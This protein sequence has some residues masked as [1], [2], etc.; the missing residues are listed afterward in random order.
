[1][2]QSDEYPV[3]GKL[4]TIYV[5]KHRLLFHVQ[6]MKT[7]EFCTHF[8]CY[9]VELSSEVLYVPACDL[10]SYLPLH[11]HTFPGRRHVRA[12]VPKHRLLTVD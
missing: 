7:L 12:I 10:V 3:F 6:V 8:H 1:M 11:M 4:L 9:V 2:I 5:I